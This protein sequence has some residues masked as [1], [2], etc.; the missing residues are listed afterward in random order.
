MPAARH[1]QP[2][3]YHAVTPYLIVK[4]ATKA[5]DFYKKVFDAMEIMRMPGPDGRIAHAEI[6]VGD[7]P[8]MLADE[9]P[10]MNALSPATVGGTPVGIMLYVA[11]VDKVFNAAIAAGA[12]SERAVADQFYGDRNGTFVDP[13]GHKWTVGTHKE[14]VTPE[15]MQGRMAKLSK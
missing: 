2:E 8:I 13:F 4:G 15:E 7:S 14:D 6:K 1:F 9:S 11:D 10:A 12:K 3:G 5:I